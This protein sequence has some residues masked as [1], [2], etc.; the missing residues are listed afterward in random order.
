MA[1]P[2]RSSSIRC[3]KFRGFFS[4]FLSSLLSLKIGFDRYRHVFIG[5]ILTDIGTLFL[6]VIPSDK[7]QVQQEIEVF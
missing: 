6:Y 1:L 5:G 7:E 3:A 4:S 2:D